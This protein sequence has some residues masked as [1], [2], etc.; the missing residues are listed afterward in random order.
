LKAIVDGRYP[1]TRSDAKSFCAFNM[2]VVYGDHNPAT[3]QIGFLEYV[4][5]GKKMR[6]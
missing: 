5:H 3:H 2:Q 1:C 4:S 6:M